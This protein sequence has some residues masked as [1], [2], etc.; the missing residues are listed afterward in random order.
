MMTIQLSNRE[1]LFTMVDDD[2]AFCLSDIPLYL[3]GQGYV[4]F[5]G[6][7]TIMLSR[8][9]LS[10]FGN[11]CVDHIDSN[12]LNN[13][14]DNLRILTMSDNNAAKAGY[15]YNT[16]YSCVLKEKK[17]YFCNFKFRGKRLESFARNTAFQAAVDVQNYFEI[18]RPS[19]DKEILFK[20]KVWAGI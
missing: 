15:L 12:P 17:K 11:H 3:N 8:Y 1:D 4:Q 2:I 14:R 16:E 9:V 13:T 7:S 5:K 6:L 20:R 10:Y 18:Y 19:L